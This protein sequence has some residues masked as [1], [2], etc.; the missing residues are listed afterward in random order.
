M[1]VSICTSEAL[2]GQGHSLRGVL[3][4]FAEAPLTVSTGCFATNPAPCDLLILVVSE[5]CL[6]AAL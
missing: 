2:A 5:A 6:H 1:N 3:R 4:S